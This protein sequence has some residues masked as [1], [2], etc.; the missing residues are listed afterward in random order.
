MAGRQRQ[1]ERPSFPTPSGHRYQHVHIDNGARAQLGDTY[2][3]G[4]FPPD[5][6]KDGTLTGSSGQES[7]LR[8]LPYATDAPFNSYSR[9]HEP[10]CLPGTRVDVLQKISK[11]ADGEDERCIFWLNGLAGT[12]KSTIARTI[13]RKYF[14]RDR[15]GASFFFS[16]GG[17]DVGRAGQF[18]TSVAIQLANKSP[19]LNR[20][21]CEAIAECSAITGQSL[22]DQWRQ[23]IL[24]PL[25]RLDGNSSPSSLVLI[26][27][28]LDEC[29]GEDDIR[30][31]IQL[32][33]EARSI[34]AIRL[35]V[36]ITSRPEIPIRY[37]FY[38]VPGT[39]HQDF[40]LH[41]VSPAIVDH[42]ISI[43]L[44]YSLK[45]IG[46]ERALGAGWPG[47]RVISVLVQKARGLFIWAATAC[48][49]IREG[50]RFAV[51]RLDMMLQGDT[52]TIAPEK[53]LDEIYITV[54]EN[55]VCHDYTE[56]EKGDAN[57]TLR[58][59]LGSVVLLSSP[60]SADSLARLLHRPKQD[61]DQTLEDLHAI[62]DVPEDR[63]RPLRLHHP[64][65]RDFLLNKDR[66]GDSHFWVDEK[67]THWA[68][69]N[70][71][72]RLMSTSLKRDICG[73]CTP[74]VLA[75]D[76]EIS[77]VEQCIPPEVQY[78]CLYWVQHLQCSG[79]QLYD[80]DVYQFLQEHFLH[81][82][83]AL[84]LMGKM[85]HG[86]ILVRTLESMLTVSR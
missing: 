82:V 48:R 42:D 66:C 62:L 84:S 20:H 32:L 11:W 36:F 60:L 63:A 51:N 33:A 7:P 59:V 34:K 58:E 28:A 76:I 85:S 45:I 55:S 30:M 5:R 17:G 56:Q 69:A 79:V 49:F 61:V 75:T 52:S 65:F 77:I 39:E 27:D 9:Q 80:N 8:L 31:I 24:R 2:H 67:Q 71:C 41:N 46:E 68:L 4:K 1:G 15:L 57:K 25:L 13:A 47:E 12:G 43:F 50:R 38:Q 78:A 26:V 14:E 3:L 19:A 83:E 10:T 6:S 74:G 22:R 18:F 54:L 64:S 29:E 16:R 37:G 44:E 73:L 35:R 70:N 40:V 86:A 53:H 72:M 21:V 81:W 23:L